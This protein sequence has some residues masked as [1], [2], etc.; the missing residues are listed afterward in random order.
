[1]VRGR[2]FVMLDGDRAVTVAYHADEDVY[3]AD[4]GRF[5]QFLDSVS[6]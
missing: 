5:R 2:E 3:E 4:Y 6:F 1:M